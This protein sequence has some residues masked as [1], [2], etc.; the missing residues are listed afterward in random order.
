[1]VISVLSIVVLALLL[2]LVL[3]I[4]FCFHIYKINIVLTENL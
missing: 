3:L 2:M 4:K 1:M